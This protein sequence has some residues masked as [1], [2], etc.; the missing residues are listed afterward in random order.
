M[1]YWFKPRFD[2]VQLIAD[3]T[4]NDTNFNSNEWS[5]LQG[6]ILISCGKMI[7]EEIERKNNEKRN[8]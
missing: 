1:S 7:I 6:E 5:I 2:L 8:I 4:I 3:R